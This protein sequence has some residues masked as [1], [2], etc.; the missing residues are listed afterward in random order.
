MVSIHTTDQ[1]NYIHYPSHQEVL[2][3][4]RRE[5]NFERYRADMIEPPDRNIGDEILIEDS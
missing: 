4:E 3:C 5:E 2:F 1:Y